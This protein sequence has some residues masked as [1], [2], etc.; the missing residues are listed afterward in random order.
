MARSLGVRL[1]MTL[2]ATIS[3]TIMVETRVII[4][5]Q[6]KKKN[7]QVTTLCF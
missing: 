3:N 6:K 2:I 5:Q 4:P 7:E 1:A